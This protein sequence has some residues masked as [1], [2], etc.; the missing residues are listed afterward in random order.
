MLA[1]KMAASQLLPLD[2]IEVKTH[3]KI[4]GNDEDAYLTGLIQSAAATFER[5]SKLLLMAAEYVSVFGR[6]A[7]ALAGLQGPLAQVLSISY[8]DVLGASVEMSS[9]YYQVSQLYPDRVHITQ[10]LDLLP[11]LA[12]HPEPILVRYLAGYT[13]PA[14]LPP[15]FRQWLLL[16]VGHW[17]ENRT[18]LVIAVNTAEVPLSAKYL[19]NLI[20]EP[21]L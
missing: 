10:P 21:T 20:R 4:D 11:L 2:L 15:E 19:M 12:L 3:C 7:G 18:P 13:A 1:R 16:M 8:V 5:E 14:Q 9:D 6:W 17:Y